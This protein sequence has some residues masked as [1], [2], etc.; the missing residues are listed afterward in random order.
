VCVC[1]A[2]RVTGVEF[3]RY[4]FWKDHFR[5]FVRAEVAMPLE[6][7]WDTDGASG[8]FVF[9][10]LDGV[11]RWRLP[12]SIEVIPGKEAGEVDVDVAWLDREPEGIYDTEGVASACDIE[13][14]IGRVAIADNWNT[15]VI[16]HDF[17]AARRCRVFVEVYERDLSMFAPWGAKTE[18]HHTIIAWPTNT[19]QPHWTSA[20][21]DATAMIVLDSYRR[22]GIDPARGQREP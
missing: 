13:A 22:S 14:P 20:R 17:G 5:Y 11:I 4:T 3:T 2:L 6:P 9:A 10:P 18:E 1:H 21:R 16:G 7:E 19:A 15:E 12:Y 8:A